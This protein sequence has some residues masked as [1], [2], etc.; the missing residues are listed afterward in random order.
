MNYCRPSYQRSVSRISWS[1]ID[2]KDAA[3]YK[4]RFHDL[5]AEATRSIAKEPE[6]IKFPKRTVLGIIQN[7]GG[8]P[9]DQAKDRQV[10]EAEKIKVSVPFPPCFTLSV[11][12]PYRPFP[13]YPMS[14]HFPL[15]KCR[16]S[17][18]HKCRQITL[19]KSATILH[20]HS[21]AILQSS[22][23]RPFPHHPKCRPFPHYPK[24]RPFPL[25]KSR[26]SPLYKCRPFPLSPHAFLLDMT[27]TER[28]LTDS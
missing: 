22:R 8:K 2:E 17:P 11:P 23:C 4:R 5:G 13:L 20:F 14:R 6:R 21:T 12:S 1:S 27:A 19:S 28:T 25:H 26:H 24:C 15:H 3:T 16:H 10:T 7:Q 9:I 18:P